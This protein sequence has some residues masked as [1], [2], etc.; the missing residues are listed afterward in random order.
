MENAIDDNKVAS[1]KNVFIEPKLIN[2]SITLKDKLKTWRNSPNKNDTEY[3][4]AN[5]SVFLLYGKAGV[6]KS[7]FTSHIIF[8]NILGDK[9]HAI[10]LRKCADKLNHKNAW[11][12]VKEI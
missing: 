3:S 1:L 9:C 6:G 12:S 11:Q 8:E 10:A 4:Y 5:A 7:S 2:E